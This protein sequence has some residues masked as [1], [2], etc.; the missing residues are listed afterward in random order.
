MRQ[1][2]S[3]WM[4]TMRRIG[5]LASLIGSVL[6]TEANAITINVM[7][8]ARVAIATGFRYTIEEDR[9]FEVIPGCTGI[10]PPPLGCPAT[11]GQTLSLN[12]HRSYM[13][14][15]ETGESSGASVGTSVLLDPTKRYFVSVLPLADATGAGKYAMGGAPVRAG[16]TSVDVIVDELPLKSAQISVLLFNDD[17]PINNAVDAPPAQ[18][19][20][21]CGFEVHLYDAG[22]TYGASGGRIFADTFGNP[23]G[24]T[25]DAAGNVASM[26]N[27]LLITD[28]NGVLR[29]K[30]LA[31][32]KYTVFA[33]APLQRP[34]EVQCPGVYQDESGTDPARI[35][36]G[37]W[38]QTS[39]LEG[40]WGIDAWVKA[41]EP[42][43][44]KE[45]GPPGHHVAMGFVRKFSQ[46][47]SLIGPSKVSGK[48]V[49]VH[50]SRPP[51]FA[52]FNGEVVDQCW[53][54]LNEIAAGVGG[55]Q[56][57]FAGPCN[58]DGSFEINGLKS[59]TQYQLAVWDT[60][61]D[62]VFALYSFVTPADGGAVALN[63]VP[64]FRW[65]GKWE[66]KVCY[67]KD[68]DGFCDAD[69]PGIP[70][71]AVNLRFRD[72]SIY[73][74]SATDDSGMYE[75]TEIFPFFNWMVTEI[76]FA[77]FKAT[78]ATVV[79][80][81]GGPVPPDNGWAMPSRNKLNPQPQPDNAG[82]PYRTEV[83]PV[84]LQGMQTFLGSTN[85][86][87]WGKQPYVGNDNGGISGIVYY[88]STRAEND[89]RFTAGENNE[90]GIPGVTV[91][92]Y[93]A[94]PTDRRK[95]LDLNGNGIDAG[96]AVAEVT[97]DSWDD[98]PPTDCAGSN[99]LSALVPDTA[100]FDGLRNY[101]QVRPSLFDGGYA[102]VE[103]EPNG[104]GT[105]GCLDGMT[106][107]PCAL[108][109]GNYIVEVVPP[110][111]YEIQKEED[112][113]VDFGEYYDVAMQALPPECVG[114]RTLPYQESARDSNGNIIFQ[115][116]PAVGPVPAELTLFP[117]VEVPAQY[118]DAPGKPRPYCNQ[119]AVT[120]T[121]QQNAPANFYLFTKAPV[122]AHI[123]GMILDDLA[124]EFSPFSPAFG[125]KYGP[126]FMPVSLRDQAGREFSRVY[127]D[128]FGTYNALV[129][130]TFS[131]NI[132]IPSG[133]SPNM[134]QA[135]LNSPYM[136]DPANP[137]QFKLDPHFNKSY[138]QFC[139]TFQYLPGKTTYLDTPVL[140]IA[141]F[142]GPQQFPLDCEA[143]SATPEIRSVTNGAGQG[144]W[145]SAPNQ[146]ITIT[147]L[148]QTEVLNPLYNQDNP[149]AINPVTGVVEPK[150]ITRDFGFGLPP[151]Q[152]IFLANPGTASETEVPVAA[153][154]WTD[155][156]ITVAV[157][158]AFGNGSTSGTVLVRRSNG[159]TTPRGVTVHLRGTAPIVVQPGQKIQAAIDAASPGQLI[160]V[161]PGM[162]EE[163]VIMN[164]RVRLQGFGAGGTL[165]NAVKQPTESQQQWRD[166]ICSILFAPNQ[167]GTQYLVPGQEFPANEIAC[168]TGDTVDNA[169]LIFG[170]DEGAGVFVMVKEVTPG[171]RAQQRLSIDGFTISGADQGGGIMVNGWAR[172]L[173]IAN[174]RITGN[175]GI[176]GGGIRLGHANL[177]EEFANN[178]LRYVGSRNTDVNIHHN[179]IVQNGNAAGDFVGG[180]GGVSLFT[181]ADGYRVADNFVCGNYSTGDG[182]GIAHIGLSVATGAGA[183]Q[184]VPT[185]RRNMVL[186]NQSF[187]QGTNPNG[188]GLAITGLQSLVT[189]DGLSTGTGTMLVD[190]NT[191]QGNLAGA[192]DGG[193][194]S[195]SGVN[196]SEVSTPPAGSNA[197]RVDIVNNVIDNNVAGVAGGGIALQDSV[198]V[199]IVNNTITRN[200]SVATGSRAFGAN[201]DQSNPQPG[202]GIAARPHSP[203]LDGVVGTLSINGLTQ[204]DFSNPVVQNSI[205]QNNRMFYWQINPNANQTNCLLN[206]AGQTC[207][208][209]VPDLSVPGAQ[210]VF[211]DLGVIVPESPP[212]LNRQLTAN[213]SMLTPT[214][215][216][217]VLGANN[218]TSD[219]AFRCTYYNG[220]RDT[221]IQL[222][223]VT[224][225]VTAAAFDEGGNFIDARFGPLT[226]LNPTS[227]PPLAPYGD[228]RIL[229]GSPANDSASVYSGI[230]ALGLDRIGI[231]R[232]A[233]GWSRGA[234]E[235]NQ[236]VPPCGP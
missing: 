140:P 182:G 122:T 154:T 199:H 63:D 208:G 134:V 148:G 187:N 95:I 135:C 19:R 18:E 48:V 127:S 191:F 219:P 147:S 24:T 215:V 90:P 189:N 81:G 6:A 55:S 83:G 102:F 116:R 138:T 128:R 173:Q 33:L 126:P 212:P 34:T 231:A 70:G 77:R 61:L 7:T 200:D 184:R 218:L 131:Y 217:P 159:R 204:A 146:T 85:L 52:F 235:G 78:G 118:R 105:N 8:P 17:N 188:G 137:G 144:P 149:S 181:G 130:S 141:A 197:Y 133:V 169:P 228:Y 209:L 234:F 175:H 236:G 174:N 86:I 27:G 39:T 158:N 23:V 125:E 123:T 37:Q 26:G 60:P 88:A 67:D 202:A 207:Y 98:N 111:G 145:V 5:A 103:Y 178:Q 1:N 216:T 226:L 115:P 224:A 183:N 75:L 54:G 161:A 139:Y 29:I 168:R 36:W 74:A 42:A 160:T 164:K 41:G 79:V 108:V 227:A 45:F 153:T 172:E 150:L 58:P 100:C 222:N 112:K 206:T 225:I 71:Q 230:P 73:Q 13:P 51:D 25:Y 136:P 99:Q 30:N 59:G 113:N 177:I 117:G 114:S 162:Y 50:M 186:F 69:E 101:N 155:A 44:F 57:V 94:D 80:D 214:S 76:D 68:G 53:V 82:L 87:E 62:Q 180:G 132:P 167:D 2:P 84:L 152:V 110:A 96:D 104:I 11:P 12:F 171:Q 156:Q 89:P 109:P 165:I 192:G 46:A 32:A 10:T 31:P 213:F 106:P 157:P 72:G 176:E 124:N 210:P 211:S 201:V 65:F 232:G 20:G 195:L 21:L 190:A 14:V 194:I 151:G 15:V 221:V 193:G 163:S 16:Q 92:L 35:R 49:N 91:R 179:E 40:T 143:P 121:A 3:G 119:V 64:V 120:L 97:T 229:N 205:V 28:V 142:A 107:V 66:G 4:R 93:R 166:K 22:G 47:T 203:A 185:I 220:D 56:G 43:F 233:S 170:T 223:E 129:P 198:N 196:G 9:T 38:S